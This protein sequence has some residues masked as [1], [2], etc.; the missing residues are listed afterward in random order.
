M[1][2]NQIPGMLWNAKMWNCYL[3][4]TFLHLMYHRTA[5]RK[6]MGEKRKS[7]SLCFA[8]NLRERNPKSWAN[9][10]FLSMGWL[11]CN[12]HFCLKILLLLSGLQCKQDALK[13]Q[14]IRGLCCGRRT[15]RTNALTLKSDLLPQNRSSPPLQSHHCLITVPQAWGNVGMGNSMVVVSVAR[16]KGWEMSLGD[17]HP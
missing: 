17:P 8:D 12:L 1:L 11:Q 15:Q 4:Q 3:W 10:C 14:P 16:G 9:V 2:S 7:Q 5:V 6:S 13:C